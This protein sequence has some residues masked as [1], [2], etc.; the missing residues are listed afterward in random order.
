MHIYAN[1]APV[2][3][4]NQSML[5]TLVVPLIVIKAIDKIPDKFFLSSNQLQFIHK[6][7][8]S[9][10]GTPP[11]GL[12]L[13]IGVQVMITSNININDRLANAMVAQVVHFLISNGH[14]KTIYLRSDDVNIVQSKMQSNLIGRVN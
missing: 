11:G 6:M 13:K 4:H 1:S 7:K 5:A 14:V 3:I 10:T 9:Q 12:N 8:L 2:D